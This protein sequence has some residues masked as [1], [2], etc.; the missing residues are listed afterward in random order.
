MYS[1]TVASIVLVFCFFLLFSISVAEEKE[2]VSK[3]AFLPFDTRAAGKY[4]SLEAGLQNMLVSRL[5]VRE[6]IEIIEHD[7]GESEISRLKKTGTVREKTALFQQLNVDYIVSGGLYSLEKGLQIQVTFHPATKEKQ[8]VKLSILAEGDEKIV[9]AVNLLSERIAEKVFGYEGEKVQSGFVAGDSGAEGFRTEHP[10]KI[11]KKGVYIGESLEGSG[12]IFSAKGVR[13]SL[14]I[15]M[16]MVSMAT[17]DLDGNG[18]DEIVL[19]GNGELRVFRY[20]K[21]IFKKVAVLPVSKFLKMHAVNITDIDQDG[22]QEIVVSANQ[23]YLISSFIMR[24]APTTGAKMLLENIPWYI[25]PLQIPGEGVVLVGQT[26]GAEKGEAIRP[27]IFRLAW[28]AGGKRLQRGDNLHLPEGVNLFDFV[29]A[30]LDMDGSIEKIIVNRSEKLLVYDHGNRVIWVSSGEFG[31]SKNYFGPHRGDIDE[32]GIFRGLGD[33]EDYEREITFIPKRIIVADANS[34]GKPDIIIGRNKLTSW[35]F[36]ENL[37]SYEGAFISCLTW[38]GSAMAELWRTN[39]ISGYVADYGFNQVQV[40]NSVNSGV[41]S[42]G[43]QKQNI[44]T[45]LVVGQLPEQG[46]YSILMPAEDETRLL[47]YELDYQVNAQYET[48]Q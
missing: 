25:R 24:W 43:D 41:V 2:T 26:R 21:G 37:R 31:G 33:I 14:K 3:V 46:I 18:Q 44:E 47:G 20:E 30:D 45:R 13:K 4:A 15:P 34:D 10:E 40:K 23:G 48:L 9:D 22:V 7:L 8:L 35:R 38:N 36:M 29:L 6:R 19:A 42:V 16:A 32:Q 17:G 27:G 28:T 11:Y 39:T 5:S 12:K 1:R